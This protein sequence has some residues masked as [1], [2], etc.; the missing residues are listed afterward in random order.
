MFNIAMHGDIEEELDGTELAAEF[1][2][3]SLQ[4]FGQ[5]FISKLRGKKSPNP[6]L[7]KVCGRLL[8]VSFRRKKIKKIC[9]LCI[10]NACQAASGVARN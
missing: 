2:L 7:K 1:S 9:V 5:E 6:L 4:K 8:N 3:S 10:H